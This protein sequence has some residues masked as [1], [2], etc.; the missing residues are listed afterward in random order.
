M[1]TLAILPMLNKFESVVV[2]INQY[3]SFI[4]HCL[5]VRFC[6]LYTGCSK[7]LGHNLLLNISKTTKDITTHLIYSESLQ[8][9]VFHGMFKDVQCEHRWSHGT[10]QADNLILAKHVTMPLH[11]ACVASA[12][13][14]LSCHLNMDFLSGAAFRNFVRNTR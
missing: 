9:Q 1:M 5:T 4:C 2:G 13:Q 6:L 11:L 3:G 8:S 7:S 12:L 10:H 14:H